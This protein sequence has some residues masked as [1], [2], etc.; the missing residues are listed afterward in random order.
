MVL[1]W[2]NGKTG[3]NNCFQCF[4]G[5]PGCRWCYFRRHSAKRAAK[6]RFNFL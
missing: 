3:L 6:L 2:F 4:R 5:A 1:L